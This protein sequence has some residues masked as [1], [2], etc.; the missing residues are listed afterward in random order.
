VSFQAFKKISMCIATI[1]N[2]KKDLKIMKMM[3]TQV[4]EKA[5]V[6]PPPSPPHC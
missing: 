2:E 1:F 3:E 5:T 4:K 6:P